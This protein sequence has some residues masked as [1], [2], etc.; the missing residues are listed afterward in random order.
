MAKYQQYLYSDSFK[1]ELPLHWKEKRLALLSMETKNAFVDGPFGSDLKTDDYKDEGIPL[2]Q[3]N[4]IRDGQH[5]L[6]NMKYISEKKKK[7][8]GLENI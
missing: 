2:I 8:L 3:L 7:D 4:N 6:K 5:I 1:T